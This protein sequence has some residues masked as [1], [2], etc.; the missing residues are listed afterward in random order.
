MRTALERDDPILAAMGIDRSALL[1]SGGEAN[2]Y[3]LDDDR[4]LRVPHGPPAATGPRERHRLVHELGEAGAPFLLPRL[5]DLRT[6]DDRVV[7]IERR[8]PGVTVAQALRTAEGRRRDGL[9]EA[10]LAASAALGALHLE[11]RGWVGE[12][13]GAGPVRRS[14]W[15]DYL[16]DRAARSL[17]RSSPDLRSVDVDALAAD[18]P[19]VI[20]PS[21]VHLDAFAGNMLTD[22]VGITAVLDF[23]VT[24][25]AGDRRFD[26]IA[27]AAYLSSPR[28]TPTARPRDAQVAASWLR[29]A[30][31]GDLA[32]PVRRWLAAFWSFAVDDVDLHA[33]CRSVLRPG[34]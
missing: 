20:T 10:H 33:W 18:L 30:G 1:G 25:I 31:L 34:P 24:S 5:L 8:L 21:F 14:S 23:G 3:A 28:I 11:D 2:V 4:V 16:R 26:P 19:G 27:T 22:G 32:R 15:H 13:I 7:T 17:R 9:V 12:L 6:I 29:D